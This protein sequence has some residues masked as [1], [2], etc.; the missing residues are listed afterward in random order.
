MPAL[1]VAWIFQLT[2]DLGH[3]SDG[4]TVQWLLQQAEL[5]IVAT[6]GTGTIPVGGAD[7][8]Q[9]D[10]LPAEQIDA[11]AG[12]PSPCGRRGRRSSP[13]RRVPASSG[14]PHTSHASGP[15]PGRAL[16]GERE[17]GGERRVVEERKNRNATYILK[18]AQPSGI[19][20]FLRSSPSPRRMQPAARHTFCSL[21]LQF[22][23]NC[24]WVANPISNSAFPR[25][26]RHTHPAT[27]AAATTT[28]TRPPW[29]KEMRRESCCG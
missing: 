1:C 15:S 26:H 11:V 22:S 29:T 28:T 9:E 4:E 7:R 17:G 21:F 2:R 8:Q 12:E 27:A 19:I 5:A 10:A 24:G 14:G 20:V 16:F 25:A 13:L 3:K 23:G 6:T 18:M